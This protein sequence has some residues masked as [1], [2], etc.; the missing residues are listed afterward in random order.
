M[1]IINKSLEVNGIFI[2]FV[3]AYMDDLICLPIVLSLVLY[4]FRRLIYKNISY[5][6]PLFFIL[7]AIIMFS[8]AFEVI[9]PG[10]SAGYISDP[11]DV[12]AYI[13]G[14]VFFHWRFNRKLSE[15]RLNLLKDFTDLFRCTV[16]SSSS[17]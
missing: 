2:P 9:L 11:F 16:R 15:T 8:L 1:F 12:L 5:C 17:L 13:A 14:G 7:T 3:H 6:F 4:I 10:K